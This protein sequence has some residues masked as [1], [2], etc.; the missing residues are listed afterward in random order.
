MKK[1]FSIIFMVLMVFFS[2]NE[3]MAEGV[4]QIERAKILADVSVYGTFILFDVNKEWNL[5]GS[6]DKESGVK[7]ARDVIYAYRDKVLV[8]SYLTLG[9]TEGSFFLLRLNTYE[10]LNSQDLIS[11]LMTTEI[12]RYLTIRHVFT[13]VTKKLNYA[14]KY[15]EILKQL[16]SIGYEG[17]LPR[18]AIIIPV[19]KDSLWWNTP[20]D[21][22]DIMMLEHIMPTLQYLSVVKR[23]LY[24]ATGI[25]DADFITYFETNSLV[26]FNDLVIA[27]RRTR[28]DS[29]NVRQGSP[30]IVG[31]IRDLDDILN[32]LKK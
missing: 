5:K 20:E 19:K 21:E 10:L 14:S 27:I 6:K 31:T 25:S 18:Y 23:K 26:D 4:K 11:R 30:T 12:G 1:K 13:G 7:E 17:E 15:P 2:V 8:D 22:R 32:I 28:E 29:Y 3:T 16:N 24:H 9:L